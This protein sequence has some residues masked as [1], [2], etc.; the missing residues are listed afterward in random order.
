M[1]TT[2]VGVDAARNVTGESNV[3]IGSGAGASWGGTDSGS[4]NVFIGVGAGAG[5]YTSRLGSN[6][7]CIGYNAGFGAT[8]DNKLYIENSNDLITPL[9][10]G[11]FQYDSVIINGDFHVI[12]NI[13]AIGTIVPDYVFEGDYELETIE[14]HA[15]YMWTNKHLP[16]LKSAVQIEEE[17]R[18][19]LNE[20]REQMLEEL[21]KAHIY[22]EQLNN[23]IK[24][25]K[26][27]NQEL[28]EKLNEIIQLL[29]EK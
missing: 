8:G 11:N 18:I 19:N 20:R 17:G 24:L 10:Y 23:D 25:M 7:I 29:E 5:A 4:S 28:K 22:I 9:I 16:A 6:N 21:E 12:G 14:E 15:N 27:E 3:V 1:S 13:T 2:I 26:A